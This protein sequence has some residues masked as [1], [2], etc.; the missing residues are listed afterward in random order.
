MSAECGVPF[1]E[2]SYARSFSQRVRKLT[3]KISFTHPQV[4]MFTAFPL[5]STGTILA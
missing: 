2:R 4:L 5:Y 1:A 3:H